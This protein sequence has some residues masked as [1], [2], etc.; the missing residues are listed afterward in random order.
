MSNKFLGVP[1]PFKLPLLEERLCEHKIPTLWDD[2][3]SIGLYMVYA[4]DDDGQE[5]LE[6]FCKKHPSK[7]YLVSMSEFVLT[8]IQGV[9]F[10]LFLVIPASTI[11]KPSIPQN[12][13]LSIIEMIILAVFIFSPSYIKKLQYTLRGRGWSESNPALFAHEHPMDVIKQICGCSTDDCTHS[14]FNFLVS[15]HPRNPT[16]FLSVK[17]PDTG[18]ARVY[19]LASWEKPS[20]KSE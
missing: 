8:C 18:P 5:N 19:F 15:H 20:E 13:A 17:G 6:E 4:T 11:G 10:V 12:V 2:S 3:M 1:K 16:R 7:K 14:P 9:L